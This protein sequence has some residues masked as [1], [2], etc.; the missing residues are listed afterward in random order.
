MNTGKPSRRDVRRSTELM[1]AHLQIA[2]L[3]QT[4]AATVGDTS[5]PSTLLPPPSTADDAFQPP[6]KPVVPP[7][8][9]AVDRVD[10][11]PAMTTPLEAQHLA[12]P[13]DVPADP[14]LWPF[15]SLFDDIADTPQPAR[16]TRRGRRGRGTADG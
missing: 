12:D 7:A 4:P 9:R 10:F 15:D 6:S 1:L 5:V 11:Q 8:L 3:P 16:R 2:Q 14:W 13:I